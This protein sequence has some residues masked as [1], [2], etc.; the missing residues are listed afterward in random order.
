MRWLEW[1]SDPDPD[2]DT[3]QVDYAFMLRE[4]AGPVRVVHDTHVEGL[5]ARATWL[6][7]LGEA[8]FEAEA[9]VFDHSELEPG[10][11]EVFLARRPGKA[12]PWPGKAGPCP[13]KAGPG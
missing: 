13:G 11:Y 4:G 5:F 3:M 6:R 1:S 12:G 7:L 9:V 8:G 10:S 2:D